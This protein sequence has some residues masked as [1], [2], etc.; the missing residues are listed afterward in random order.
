MDLEKII[1]RAKD[2]DAGFRE[3]YDGTFDRVYAYVLARTHSKFDTSE[4]CQ[5]IYV[6][7]WKSLQRF[8]YISPAHFWGFLWT[9][10]R[11]ELIRARA[12]IK[13][14]VS[15]EDI[16]DIPDEPEHH[17][18]YRYLLESLEF[19]KERQ[20][21]VLELRYFSDLTFSEVAQMLGISE[22]NA[23]VLHHRAIEA[24]KSKFP[25]YE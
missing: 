17:E 12:K 3:L 20:R 11:R 6:S 8:E 4:I 18:D 10:V 19:L 5:D 2:G 13:T 24:L 21:L 25:H 22:S 7:L 15:L 14:T 1:K 9:V 23:K 16:Y